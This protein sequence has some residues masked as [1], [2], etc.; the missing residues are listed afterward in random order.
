MKSILFAWRRLP[1]PGF[2]GGAEITEG[3]WAALLAS[4]GHDVWFVG[5]TENPRDPKMNAHDWLEQMLAY[6]CIEPSVVSYERIEYSWRGVHCICVP[7]SGVVAATMSILAHGPALLWTSQE[8]CDEIAGLAG[9]LPLASYMHSVSEVGM[10]SA[11]LNAH[12]LLAPSRFVQRTAQTQKGK[13]SELARPI[14]QG[15][16]KYPRYPEKHDVVLLVNP[17]PEKGLDTALSI[18]QATP[19]H[20]FVF[21]EGWRKFESAGRKLPLNV[22][23]LARQPSLELLYERTRVLIVP[24]K[25]PDAAPRVVLE[26]G[27]QGI[28]VVGSATGGIPELVAN[29]IHN[30]IPTSSHERWIAR[31]RQIVDDDSEWSQASR[32]QYQRSHELIQ[33]PVSVIAAT[34]LLEALV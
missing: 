32:D 26:A 4:L 15:V 22:E 7:Q 11:E 17:I 16:K 34:G 9:S 18:A 13:S 23:I 31:I 20:T 30:C 19:D 25:I 10:L 27:Q 29:P 14:I 33:D 5:S 3:L 6:E 1:P 24:S 8:G 2:I 28:P 12:Y 21:V